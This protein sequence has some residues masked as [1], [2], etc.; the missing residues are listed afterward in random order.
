MNFLESCEPFELADFLFRKNPEHPG[1]TWNYLALAAENEWLPID[2]LAQVY[3]RELLNAEWVSF[4]S[5]F[6]LLRHNAKPDWM[7]VKDFESLQFNYLQVPLL[8]N[9]DGPEA[10][11]RIFRDL[12]ARMLE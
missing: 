2:E 5:C 9:M 6:W 3:K 4:D 7:N 1:L 12:L 11:W 10:E 8:S